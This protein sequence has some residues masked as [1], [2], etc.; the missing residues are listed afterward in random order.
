MRRNARPIRGDGLIM[1]PDEI[2]ETVVFFFYEKNRRRRRDHWRE[3]RFPRAPL[4]PGKLVSF[5]FV[6]SSLALRSTI[7]TT[8]TNGARY[9]CRCTTAVIV[10]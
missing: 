10:L 4:A 6:Y 7:R 3:K 2:R 5:F 9:Q 8:D 1:S